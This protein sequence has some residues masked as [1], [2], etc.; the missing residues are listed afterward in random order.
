MGIQTE[1]P[2]GLCGKASAMLEPTGQEETGHPKL[3]WKRSVDQELHQS[4][5]DWQKVARVAQD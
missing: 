2:A 4:R 3:T 1:N 5:S